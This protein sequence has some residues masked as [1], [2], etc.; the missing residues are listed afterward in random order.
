MALTAIV[1]ADTGQTIEGAYI[2]ISPPQIVRVTEGDVTSYALRGNIG[3]YFN[4]DACHTF[5][6]AI[7]EPQAYDCAYDLGTAEAPSP[8]AFEQAYTWV[9]ANVYPDATDV[10]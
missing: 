5:K 8:N 1:T 9:K 10:L 7:C 2:R 3:V 6:A 4:E